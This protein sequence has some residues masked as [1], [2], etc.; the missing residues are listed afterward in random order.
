MAHLHLQLREYIM[1]ALEAQAEQRG[2]SVSEYLVELLCREVGGWPAD[3][4]SEVIGGWQGEP[5][6]RPPQGRLR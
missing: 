1:T 4:F 5:L 2:M 3:F 6:E